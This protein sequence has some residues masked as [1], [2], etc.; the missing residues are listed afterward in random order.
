PDGRV[1]AYAETRQGPIRFV[2]A[3]DGKRLPLVIE[4]PRPRLTDVL[5]GRVR[6]SPDGRR[7]YYVAEDGEG[8][9]GIFEQ[10][11]DAAKTDTNASRR[12]VYGFEADGE[13]ESFAVS[14][15]GAR[16]G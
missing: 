5:M 9:C 1:V 11:F 13:T 8:R 14:P 10:D 7:V 4:T 12:R 3:K 15:D 2:D 6:W 16:L